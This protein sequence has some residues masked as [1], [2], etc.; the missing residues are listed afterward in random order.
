[1]MRRA[2]CYSLEICAYLF[3]RLV[4]G[5]EAGGTCAI[6]LDVTKDSCSLSSEKT[7]DTL[8]YRLIIVS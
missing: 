7:L 2:K 8:W 4:L 3:D 6:V 5:G 1:M